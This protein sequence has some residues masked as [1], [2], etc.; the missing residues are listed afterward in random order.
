MPLATVN[1]ATGETLVTFHPLT[2]AELDA[3]LARAEAAFFSWR[4]LSFAQRAEPFLRLAALFE[5]ER[6]QERLGR[7]VTLEMGKPLAAAKGEAAKCATGCRYY[8][9]HAG[10]LLAE[11]PVPG[12]EGGRAQVRYEPLG[13]VL[14]L[15]PWNFPL[16]QVIRC[17]VPA[18]MAGNTVVLK[19]ADGV[20]QTAAA[21]EELFLRAGFPEGV[22]QNLQIEIPAVERVIDDRRVA[23]AS[24]TGSVTAGR[25]VAA[26]AGKTLKKVVLELGGND[27]FLVLPGADLE[28]VVQKAVAA[29]G[30][31]AG[32]SCIAAKRF[33]VETS[34]YDA[35]EA[36]FTAAFSA[37]RVGDPLAPETEMGPLVHGRAVEALERQI[38][39]AVAAGARVLCGGRRRPGLGFYFEPTVLAGLP[40]ESEPAREEEFFGPVALL[41]RARDVG[42]A[43]E[44]ANGTPFGLGASAWTSDEAAQRRCVE[45]IR[46]GMV[47]VNGIVAS[48]AALPF[49]GIGQSGY[50]RE[51]GAAGIRE[52]TNAKTVF[53]AQ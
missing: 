44:L 31:N 39:A 26:Q 53:I 9:E 21:L 22:F 52:F 8:A 36:K 46:A 12:V 15:M 49:G 27:P 5:D 16:W 11:E 43:I 40:P 3:K 28:S 41:F 32:Q 2:E 20:P 13:V 51:L 7:L 38:A 24:L 18:L 19:H 50:G 45:E 42:H 17:A 48:Q 1:P 25:A 37:L 30:Q 29:R 34:L 10:R 6:E 4:R 14:A 23:A 35:F 33:I 47:F